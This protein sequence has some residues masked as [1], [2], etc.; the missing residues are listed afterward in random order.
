M[1]EE[2]KKNKS[3]WVWSVVL[4][5]L[6]LGGGTYLFI[7]SK[8]QESVTYKEYRV[9]K[10]DLDVT[11]S[12]TGIVQPENRVEV[13]APIAGRVEEVLIQEGDPVTKG[14]TLAWMSS[15]ERA[16]L[17]DAARSKGE[18]EAK[19]WERMYRSTPILAPI[20]GMIIQRNIESGQ[21]F[22]TQDPI[23]VMSDRLTVKAQVDETD[24]AKIK[25]KEKAKITLDAYPDQSIE[26]HVDQIAFDAKTVNNVTTY[27]VDVLPENPPAFMRSGM[28]ANV[29]FEVETKS[30]VLLIPQDA[31]KIENGKS[32]VQV[33]DPSSRGT[34]TTV[35]VQTGISDGKRIEILQGLE[36][37]AKIL[38]PEFRL[39]KKKTGS[40]NPFSP[41]GNRPKG[42]H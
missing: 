14:Q 16:A 17:L 15:T 11:I 13:K 1:T 31:V 38:L 4:F 33:P 12:S 28:T 22:T 26:G 34:P 32:V 23:F 25:L 42:R 6:G 7:R 40:S 9:E 41:M 21:T 27:I 36:E 29:V 10:G 20:A 19:E 18:K 30:D 8:A 3:M 24:I 39:G 35:E 2:I 5:L 37:G